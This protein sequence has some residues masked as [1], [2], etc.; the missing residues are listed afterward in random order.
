MSKVVLWDIDKTFHEYP[1]E[2]KKNYKKNY[3]KLRQNY[4]K[5]IGELCIDH[6]KSRLWHSLTLSRNPFKSNIYKF[7]CVL[8]TLG[9]IKKKKNNN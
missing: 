7:I 6:N 3:I 8:E 1:S 2:V 9:S 5:W 4:S